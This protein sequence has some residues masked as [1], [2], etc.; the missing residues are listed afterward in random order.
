VVRLRRLGLKSVLSLNGGLLESHRG[1]A[2]GRNARSSPSLKLD[3]QDV[4]V[5][6]SDRSLSD[7][8][9]PMSKVGLQGQ[10]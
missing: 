3:K 2:E 7:Y 6:P 10:S 1:R 9:R 8:I 4:I 5:S